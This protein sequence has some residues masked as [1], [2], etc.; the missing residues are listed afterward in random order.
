MRANTRLDSSCLTMI[1]L[2]N[3]RLP[4]NNEKVFRIQFFIFYPLFV[5]ILCIEEIFECEHTFER[6]FLGAIF[7]SNAP[8][9]IAGWRSDFSDQV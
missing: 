4:H 8:F 3:S 1:F 6:I 2:F 9:F 5:C 7:G